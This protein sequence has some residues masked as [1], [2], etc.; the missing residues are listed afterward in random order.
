MLVLAPALA[1]VP[2]ASGAEPTMLELRRSEAGTELVAPGGDIRATLVERAACS[3]QLHL[4][5]PRG[6]SPDGVR[7]GNGH[8]RAVEQAAAD[9]AL[10]AIPCGAAVDLKRRGTEVALAIGPVPRPGRKPVTGPMPEA[11][12]AAVA[13]VVLMETAGPAPAAETPGADDDAFARAAIADGLARAEQPEQ[14]D[15]AAAPPLA[16]SPSPPPGRPDPTWGRGGP[17]FDLAAWRTTPFR[18]ERDRLLSLIAGGDDAG[19][20]DATLDLARLYL[21]W[22]LGA[23]VIGLLAGSPGGPRGDARPLAAA[24]ATI[25]RPKDSAADWFLSAE[26]LHAADG[27]LW[28]AVTLVRRGRAGEIAP[29]LPVALPALDRL[30]PDLR[31]SFALAL[32]EGAAAT[33]STGPARELARIVESGDLGP[34]EQARLHR[35]IGDLHAAAG[36]SA[37]ALDQWDRA[38]TLPGEDGLIARVQAAA[39]RHTAGTLDDRAYR[40]TLGEILALNRGGA[41]EAAALIRLAAL[42][43]AVG[44]IPAAL[45][46]ITRLARHHP[47]HPAI[48]EQRAIAADL[49]GTLVRD[50][51]AAGVAVAPLPLALPLPRRIAAMEAARPLLPPGEDGRAL[52]LAYAALLAR[53]GLTEAAR[54]E[55]TDLAAD[56]A[57]GGAAPAERQAILLDLSAQLVTAGRSTDA[58]VVLDDPA[59]HGLDNGPDHAAW[60]LARITALTAAGETAEAERLLHQTDNLP[61]DAVATARADILWR[62]GRWP[63]AAAALDRLSPTR[64][65][66]AVEAR[67]AI[68]TRYLAHHLADSGPDAANPGP[69]PLPHDDPWAERLRLLAPALST[70]PATA[71]GLDALLADTAALIRVAGPAPSAVP[72]R[73]GP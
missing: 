29:Y 1:L 27:P 57:A 43:R 62:A 4:D 35:R 7:T 44:D 12:A 6:W 53:A 9:L 50:D 28:A 8:V 33:G 10:I 72:R 40:A 59:A 70:P 71:A 3:V 48:A 39:T 25:A 55:L 63:E 67:R 17:L 65:L 32:L 56:S 34:V 46:A 23:D 15:S 68:L 22:D 66:T 52:R 24:A 73:D 64:P 47:T 42:E 14:A 45:E 2:A 19:N 58:L 11:P 16:T 54:A 60:T 49:I 30:P 37:L 20:S 18:A 38:A 21:A 13:Q 61:P 69:A 36:R 5:S 51:G 26:A 31:Q 41:G